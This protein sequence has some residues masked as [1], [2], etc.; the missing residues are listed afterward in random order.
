ML[1][2]NIAKVQ[3]SWRRPRIE[4]DGGFEATDRIVTPSGFDGFESTLV[5]DEPQNCLAAR[6]GIG[7][8][9]FQQ[10]STDVV[11]L[12]PLV[13]LFVKFLQ[14]QKGVLILWIEAERFGERLECSIDEAPAFE[15]KPKAE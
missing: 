12:L 2:A 6:V 5:L 10:L 8:A 4:I 15:I 13:L 14:V 11:R 7:T 3:V 9:E 1:G